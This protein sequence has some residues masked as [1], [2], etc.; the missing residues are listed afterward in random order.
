MGPKRP[1]HLESTVV[2][3]NLHV[4]FAGCEVLPSCGSVGN[5]LK[6]N[7]V[8]VKPNLSS[9]KYFKAL[10]KHHKDSSTCFFKANN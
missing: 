9:R 5:E 10:P 8:H 1:A 3:E 2:V 7:M 6:I 4:G